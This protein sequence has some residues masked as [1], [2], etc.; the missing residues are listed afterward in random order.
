MSIQ[1]LQIQIHRKFGNFQAWQ[2]MFCSENVR[3]KPRGGV[4]NS[5]ENSS[6]ATIPN[7]S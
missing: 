3:S 4:N 2:A 5:H 1:T 7:L 6:I